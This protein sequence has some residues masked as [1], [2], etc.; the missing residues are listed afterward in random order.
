MESSSS[1]WRCFRSKRAFVHVVFQPPFH[2]S[3]HASKVVPRGP[4]W[5]LNPFPSF[6][7]RLQARNLSAFIPVS[8]PAS[9]DHGGVAL[10][11]P[12][13]QDEECGNRYDQEQERAHGRSD[14]YRYLMAPAETAR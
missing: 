8:R 12:D 2:L 5:Y 7:R 14:Y 10:R 6:P 1:F 13:P 3:P 4:F 11:S 9:V